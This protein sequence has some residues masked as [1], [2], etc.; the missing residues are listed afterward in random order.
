M[1]ARWLNFLQTGYWK[2]KEIPNAQEVLDAAIVLYSLQCLSSDVHFGV[3]L[4]KYVVS[5]CAESKRME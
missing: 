5:D 4:Q 1:K 3:E 2:E